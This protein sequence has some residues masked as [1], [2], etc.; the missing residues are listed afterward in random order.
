MSTMVEGGRLVALAHFVA[1]GHV[2]PNLD[3]VKVLN[4]HKRRG[5]TPFK[6][7]YH[8]LDKIVVGAK[9]KYQPKSHKSVCVN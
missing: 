9:G 1:Y 2:R 7:F 6:P 5:S 8:V 4:T 3:D